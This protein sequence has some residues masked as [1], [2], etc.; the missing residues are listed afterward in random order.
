MQQTYDPSR[1]RQKRHRFPRPALAA[2]TLALLGVAACGT[3]DHG[4]VEPELTAAQVCGSTL[5]SSAAAAL[6]R[7]AG[8]DRFHEL[9]GTDEAG[10]PNKFS[11]KLAAGSLHDDASKRNQ[12]YVTKA[13][14]KTGYPL[15]QVEFSAEKY[16]PKADMTS[17]GGATGKTPYPIG[18]YA[19]THE[20]SSAT[21]YFACPTRAPGKDASPTPTPYVR[22]YLFAN[23]PKISPNTGEEDLMVI[24]NPVARAMAKQLGCLSQANLPVHVPRV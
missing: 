13:E 4:T 21:I 8:T 23:S 11:L 17:G 24:L 14:D 3:S 2:A 1:H 22:G 10:Q 12:C 15:I 20:R 5:D 9:P 7:V 18:V 6:R 19:E 16:H